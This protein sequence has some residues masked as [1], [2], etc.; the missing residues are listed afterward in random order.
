MS[1]LTVM[2]TV[3]GSLPYTL[4]KNYFGIGSGATAGALFYDASITDDSFEIA[5]LSLALAAPF[6]L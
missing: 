2:Y 6:D 3:A 5:S 1:V 4:Y